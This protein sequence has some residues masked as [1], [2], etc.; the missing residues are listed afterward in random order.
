MRNMTAIIVLIALFIAAP[1]I[2]SVHTR[3]HYVSNESGILVVDVQAMSDEG[4]PLINLYRGAFKISETLEKRVVAVGFQHFVFQ[5]DEYEQLVGYTSEYRKVTWVYTI[6]DDGQHAGIPNDWTTILRVV[7]VFN[8]SDEN[9]TITWAGSPSYLV[10]DDNGTDITG[11]YDP[12]PPEL[13]DFPLPVELATFSAERT[14]NQVE[15]TW[16]TESELNN[17]G[18]HVYRSVTKEEGYAR[19]TKELIRGQ[20]STTAAH[21]YSYVDKAIDAEKDYWY[22][23]ETVSTDGLSTYYGPIEASSMSGVAEDISA[24]PLEFS[25]AQNYPNPFNPSTEIR[26]H[27]AKS[28]AMTLTVYDV[29]GKLVKRLA[30]GI[31]E[32]GAYSVVWNGLDSNG[33]R[34]NSGIYIYELKAGNQVFYHKMTL[35]K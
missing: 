1:L 25:L 18:F 8:I 7:V 4:A 11:D 28:S 13:Q 9:A 14:A 23:I 17:L 12:I 30:S 5:A 15:L 22:T 16:R 20:G 35:I 21:D 32:A 29:R 26:Y 34:V 27:L 3:L 24:T 6:R 33:A 19:I 2:A 31:Q 10:E